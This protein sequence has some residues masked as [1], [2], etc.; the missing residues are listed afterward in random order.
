M[1]RNVKINAGVPYRSVL[2]PIL[3]NILYHET[4]NLGII[5]DAITVWYADDFE[6]V[7]D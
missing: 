3:C 6:A 4:S 5:K 2:G 7:E 1:E